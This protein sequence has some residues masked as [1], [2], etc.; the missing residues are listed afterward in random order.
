MSRFRALVDK[1]NKLDL[2][3]C[4]LLFVLMFVSALAQ[5]VWRFIFRLSLGFSDELC[6]FAMIYIV[7]L[8]IPLALSRGRML[9]VEALAAPWLRR[10]GTRRR[11]VYRAAVCGLTGLFYAL[12]ALSA[13]L[14]MGVNAAQL[15]PAMDLPMSVP[16][17]AIL[18]GGILTALNCAAIISD[19]GDA[20]EAGIS[21]AA[22]AA[23]AAA[24]TTAEA[25]ESR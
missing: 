4:E 23:E 17:A 20:P 3:L 22:E 9:R 25:G 2:W 13:L 7:F 21:E 16:Y 11:R 15:S 5:V 6:R 14:M 19:P 12:A 18:L 24:E 10:G 8:A 1:I